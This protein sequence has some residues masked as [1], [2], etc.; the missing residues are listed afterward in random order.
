MGWSVAA[1]GIFSRFSEWFGG[2]S[3]PDSPHATD[4]LTRHAEKL[5]R[6]RGVMSVGL[7]QTAS[8]E[9][10]IVVGLENPLSVPENIP[11]E[12]EGIP[13]VVQ[14]VSRPEAFD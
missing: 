3:A 6:L 10:A 9:V 13:V 11:S 5:M 1:R 14:D 2:Q 12:V 4:V 8:G 7:G